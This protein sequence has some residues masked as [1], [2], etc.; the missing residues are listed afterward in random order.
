[1][2]TIAP[3]RAF[4]L[5]ELLVVVAVIALLIGLLLPALGKARQSAWTIVAGNMQ[6]QLS[7]GVQAYASSSDGWIPGC[8]SSGLSYETGI[9][10]NDP[11]Y[12]RANSDGSQPVQCWDWISPALQDAGLPNGIG[13]RFRAIFE[14]FADPAMKVTS[15]VFSTRESDWTR[16]VREEVAAR[17]PM[18][19]ISFL[20]PGNFQW[21]SRNPQGGSNPLSSTGGG[22]VLDEN[23]GANIAYVYPA[24]TG[25]VSTNPADLPSYR[26][27]LDSL[28]NPSSKVANVTAF[29]FLPS[30]LK[31]D[32]DATPGD[33]MLGS[34]ACG[35]ATT[36][37]SAEF[38][39]ISTSLHQNRGDVNS[40]TYR[41]A[42]RISVAMFDGSVK[43]LTQSE[44]RNPSLWFPR[45][46][47]YNG[48]EAHP[49]AAQFYKVG[50]RIN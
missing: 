38:G 14:R 5:V 16:N 35:N 32:F 30:D 27:R 6:R 8:N 41:H 46:F 43:V 9:G 47:K 24:F 48:V 29:R 7:L 45:G 22:L 37:R 23:T 12:K 39:D 1:M 42:G 4:T 25:P 17:G 20:M 31:P 3:R 40:L 21:Y 26:P 50:D 18:V 2:K 36:R 33:V 34:F 44:S 11:R 15:T 28:Q 49:D 10:A 13:Q 19:G